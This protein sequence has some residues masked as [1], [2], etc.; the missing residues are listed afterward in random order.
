MKNVVLTADYLAKK[1][2]NTGKFVILSERNGKGV[3]LV[4]FRLKE[5]KLYDEVCISLYGHET[6]ANILC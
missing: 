1:L 3:P 6:V 2:E 5:K 4:A